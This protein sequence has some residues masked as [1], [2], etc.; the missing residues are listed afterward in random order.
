MRN[1]MFSFS[2][3]KKLEEEFADFTRKPI[4]RRAVL[5]NEYHR[6]PHTISSFGKK[7]FYD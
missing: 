5:D 2:G 1:R 3:S 6:D 4:R 7:V